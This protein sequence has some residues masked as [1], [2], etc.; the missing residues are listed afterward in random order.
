MLGQLIEA[1]A[2]V[3]RLNMSHPNTTGRGSRLASAGKPRS[4]RRTGHSL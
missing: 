1:G 2:N 4:R 3:F